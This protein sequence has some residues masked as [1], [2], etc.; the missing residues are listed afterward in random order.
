MK[1]RA[2]IYC[3]TATRLQHDGGTSTLRQEGEC[4]DYAARNGLDVTAVYVETGASGNR[5]IGERPGLDQ[6]IDSLARD[7]VLIV[8][9]LTRLARDSEGL[10]TILRVVA[11]R[12]AKVIAVREKDRPA[13]KPRAVVYMR[14]DP[15][16]AGTITGV[17]LAVQEATCID[18]AKRA[19]WEVAGV[20]CDAGT[21][22]AA[23][24][25]HRGGLRAA[26]DRLEQGG[27]LVVHDAT[28][29]LEPGSKTAVGIITRIV[30]KGARIVYA[31]GK[32]SVP[33]G[34]HGGG[35]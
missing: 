8:A 22:A 16:S 12:D 15:Y 5:A 19:G 28:R 11:H 30:M 33:P 4:R 6:A 29:L 24:I 18:Y 17:P 25:D 35:A 26:V 10:Q 3:R 9:D 31:T 14:S 20:E 2:V 13:P 23:S 1:R 21:T 34:V 32:W 7:D 27:F